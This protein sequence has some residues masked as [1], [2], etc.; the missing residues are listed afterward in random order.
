M[1]LLSLIL[2]H[3]IADFYLQTDEMVKE[4]LRNL[5]KHTAHH[6]ICTG[7]ILAV[8]FMYH[9]E[10]IMMNLIFPWVFIVGSHFFIDILKIKILDSMKMNHEEN[11]KRLGFFLLDQALHLC[12]IFI[13]GQ[14]FFDMDIMRILDFFENDRKLNTSNSVLFFIIIVI[15]TTS[16]SGHMIK[17]LLGSLPNQL[18]TF[19]G[20][21]VF[22]NERKE[23]NFVN[24]NSGNK[25]MMEEYNYSIFS[26]HD[27]SRGKL[28]GYIERLLVL[29][30]T[31]YG[32]YPAIGFIVAAK[33][34]ARFKQMDDRDWA[35]YFL[36]GTLSSMFI[37]ITFGILLREVLT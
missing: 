7:M 29:L 26:K 23:A 9:P 35:E 1:L 4:K 2:V 22:K 37:G 12:V 33:S 17:I 5:K 27:L 20:R 31:F 8:F 14:L 11:L 34:I 21:Y 30:L 10:E 24:K 16:V 13:S 15:L 6:F 28:I 36:L 25:G 32:A 18:L 3:L 19:E